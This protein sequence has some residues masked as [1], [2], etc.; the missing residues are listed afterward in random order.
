MSILDVQQPDPLEVLRSKANSAAF[1]RD[2]CPWLHVEDD[3]FRHADQKMACSD[4]EVD[5]WSADLISDGYFSVEGGRLQWA[6]NV[7]DVARGLETLISKGFPPICIMAYDEPWVMGA[8]LARLVQATTGGNQAIMDWNAFFVKAGAGQGCAEAAGWP[9][10]RD[11][12]SFQAALNGFR[13]DGTPRYTTF[14]IALTDATPQSSCLMVVPRRW[15]PGYSDG[16]KGYLSDIFSSVEAYQ[17]IRALPVASGGLI[18][19]SH[20]LMHWGSAAD[21]RASAPRIAIAFAAADPSFEEPYFQHEMLAMPSLD[22][23]VAL[24]GGQ[25]LRYA[26]NE[27]FATTRA[28]VSLFYGLFL[29]KGELF[30]RSYREEVRAINQRLHKRL[31][32]IPATHEAPLKVEEE[33]ADEG[34]CDLFDGI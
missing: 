7:A 15:D 5:T 21:P 9:P 20:R 25:V 17:Y 27:Q 31:P 14:W 16:D 24:I 13:A 30:A 10:H 1:W 6:V 23:R 18:A 33:A 32:L 29:G 8:Q 3:K 12:G 4:A 19:F 22:V 28:R 34:I 26:N 2:L 11:R